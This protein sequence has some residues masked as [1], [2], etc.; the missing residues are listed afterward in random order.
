MI[1]GEK[2]F[3]WLLDIA[4][5]CPEMIFDV[6]GA[7]NTDSDYASNLVKRACEIRNVKMH[8]R[9]SHQ[10]MPAY[11]RSS[12]ILCCTSAYEGFPNTFLEAWSVG[13]PVVSTF[14]PDDVVKDYMD[15]YDAWSRMQV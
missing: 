11:Y 2:R 13:V 12:D 1:S 3:E 14:D 9:I 10:E 7:S 15:A 4:E 5:Q 8:G 6:V